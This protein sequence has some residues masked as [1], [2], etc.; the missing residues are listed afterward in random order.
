[1][2]LVN[3]VVALAIVGTA[4]WANAQ[5]PSSSPFAPLEFLIGSCWAGTF[6]DGKT[7]D[8]HCF[9]W[10]LDR[11]FVRDHHVVGSPPQQY[12]GESTYAW[13]ASA[14][15]L[16]YRY[17]SNAGLLLDGTMEQRGNQ[18]VSLAQYAGAKGPVSV[19]A[20]WTRIGDSAYRAESFEKA[21][22]DWKPMFTVEYHPV[23]R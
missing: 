21:G 1:M 6:A 17:V 18:V 22:D 12:E 4:S 23:K 3:A 16:I 10:F 9:D 2:R 11:K 8:T 20:V 13:D 19:R 7:I 14:K 15:R 5:Q